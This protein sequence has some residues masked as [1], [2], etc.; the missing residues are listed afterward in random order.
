M[1]FIYKCVCRN[2]ASLSRSSQPLVGIASKKSTMDKYLIDL[3][4]I[5]SPSTNLFK[6]IDCRPLANAIANRAMYTFFV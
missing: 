6:L 3:M 4:R 5:N 2:G 1:I